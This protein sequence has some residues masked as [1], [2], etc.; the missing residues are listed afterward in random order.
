MN[1]PNGIP[2]NEDITVLENDIR[3]VT[4][5]IWRNSG[6]A[7]NNNSTTR[8]IESTY[9]ILITKR[10]GRYFPFPS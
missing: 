5:M 1:T 3:N 8:I 4:P 2:N 7:T 10:K 6:S 9:F